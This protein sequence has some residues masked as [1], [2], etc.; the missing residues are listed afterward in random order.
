MS[1]KYTYENIEYIPTI[2]FI[3]VDTDTYYTGQVRLVGGDYP[4]EGRVE[5]YVYDA[6]STIYTSTYT[7][8]YQ[9]NAD[10]VCRQLGYTGA[11]YYAVG[12]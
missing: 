12:V 1:W 6:W 9:D 11:D 10:S 4:S 7:Y 5:I 3:A 2:C 8:N